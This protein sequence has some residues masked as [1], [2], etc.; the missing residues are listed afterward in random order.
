L[1]L[2]KK[3]FSLYE[4]Y[5]LV[6][7]DTRVGTIMLQNIFARRLLFETEIEIQLEVRVFILWLAIVFI[8]ARQ[9]SDASHS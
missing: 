1:F 3:L 6:S 9:S 7:E 4:K 5:Y 8:S 2:K